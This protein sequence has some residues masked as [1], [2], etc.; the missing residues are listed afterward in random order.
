MR[1]DLVAQGI[2]RILAQIA[3]GTW[4]EGAALPPESQLAEY[5]DVSRPTMR[6]VVRSLADRGVLDVVHG[7]G[8]FVQP[9]DRWTS[10]ETVIR[11][12]SATTSQRQMGRWLV[13]VRRMI[14]VGS[15]GLAAQNA[16]AEDC[17]RMRASLEDFTA[18]DAA[19]DVA[20]AAAADMEFHSRVIAATGNPLLN[21]AIAP[22]AE[23][24]TRSREATSSI[25]EVRARAL[26]HHQTIAAA[27][28][29]GDPTRAKNAMRAHMEQTARDI[30]SF[31]PE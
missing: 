17:A 11:T 7:R 4:A 26:H 18:A 21:V 15:T 3:D 25:P 8:T 27:I 10:M 29:A 28:A 23:A 6:E 9:I 1:K 13:Q 2:D 20:R 12:L 30:E 14:E 22:L 24:L 5:L 31:L 16:T 19:G